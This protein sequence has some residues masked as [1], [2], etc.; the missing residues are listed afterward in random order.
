MRNL[1][2]SGSVLLPLKSWFAVDYLRDLG[3]NSPV[4][5]VFPPSNSFEKKILDK[6]VNLEYAVYMDCNG[7]WEMGGHA[8]SSMVIVDSFSFHNVLTW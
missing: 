4:C 5:I 6:N 1:L 2:G 3:D 7:F 8:S